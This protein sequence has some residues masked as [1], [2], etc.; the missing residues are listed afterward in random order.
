MSGPVPGGGW[1]RMLRADQAA[2]SP[3]RNLAPVPAGAS[4]QNRSPDPGATRPL[5]HRGWLLL[6]ACLSGNAGPGRISPRGEQRVSGP[7]PGGDLAGCSGLIK[8]LARLHGT[9]APLLLALRHRIGLQIQVRRDLSGTGDGSCWQLASCRSPV[10]RPPLCRLHPVFPI[11][12]V[13]PVLPWASPV[14][15]VLRPAPVA[16][17]I[18]SLWASLVRAG[19]HHALSAMGITDAGVGRSDRRRSFA[20]LCGPDCICRRRPRAALC[21]L[22]LSFFALRNGLQLVIILGT[23]GSLVRFLRVDAFR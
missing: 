8:R 13:S 1:R 19:L 18:P 21:S 23:V 4:P 2:G 3:S 6:A 12:P 20:P 9:S 17:P 7:V 14:R 10:Q 15:P 5:R 22:R 11:P 16:V